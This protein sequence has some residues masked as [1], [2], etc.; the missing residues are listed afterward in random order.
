MIYF[1]E[2]VDEEK[3]NL[4]ESLFDYALEIENQDYEKLVINLSIVSD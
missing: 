4:F 1:T 2:S 3:K